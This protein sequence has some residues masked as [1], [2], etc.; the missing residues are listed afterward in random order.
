VALLENQIL[1]YVLA[2][3]TSITAI[4][5]ITKF[6]ISFVRKHIWTL[7]PMLVGMTAAILTTS[8]AVLFDKKAPPAD[9]IAFDKPLED[10]LAEIEKLKKR[11]ENILN[12]LKQ[13][14]TPESGIDRTALQKID[15]RVSAIEDGVQKIEGIIATDAERL[16]SVPILLREVESLRSEINSL[17]D[18]QSLHAK[19]FQDGV[20]EAKG[21][22]RWILGTLGVGLLA[23]VVPLVR[24]SMSKKDNA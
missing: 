1:F 6:D 19:T 12:A 24:S 20:S 10:T 7:L 2:I 5:A 8:T 14:I 16:V 22:A 21:Q 4:L 13:P 15:A 3:I 18:Q 9:I 11:Q 17:K 23:L